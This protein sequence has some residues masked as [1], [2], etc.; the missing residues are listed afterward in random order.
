MSYWQKSGRYSWSSKWFNVLEKVDGETA[1]MNSRLV[2]LLKLWQSTGSVPQESFNWSA[3]KANWIFS[4]PEHASFIEN[5]PLNINRADLVSISNSTDCNVIEK[6]LAVMIWGYGD[7]GYGPFR[8]KGMLGQANSTEVL[9][10][11]YRLASSGQPID[12]Y[13]LLSRDRIKGLGPSYGTK[14][15]SFWTPRATGAPIFDS[16]IGKWLS[17]F[18]AVEFRNVPTEPSSWHIKSY[19]TYRDWVLHH[20]EQLSCFSDEVELA[21]FRESEALFSSRSSWRPK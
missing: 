12:A 10:N 19:K 14:V 9:E 6:F 2:E 4:F 15:I 11:L 17:E 7:R 21:I 16:F 13:S 3:S 5:L 1:F 18:A 20:S 8:V